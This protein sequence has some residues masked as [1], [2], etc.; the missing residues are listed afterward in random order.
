MLI[1]NWQK[2]NERVQCN[3]ENLRYQVE[4]NLGDDAY[5]QDHYQH[6]YKSKE[7]PNACFQKDFYHLCV[8][9]CNAK[10]VHRLLLKII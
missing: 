2:G 1:N 6:D 4:Y 3:I 8:R 5:R 9:H 10:I 7:K